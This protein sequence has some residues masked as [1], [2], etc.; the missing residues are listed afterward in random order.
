MRLA[1]PIS[2][3]A[4]SLIAVGKCQRSLLVVVFVDIEIQQ[5]KALRRI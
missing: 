3:Y 4:N 2:T 5:L 1:F